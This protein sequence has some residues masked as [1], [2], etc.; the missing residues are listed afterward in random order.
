M[1]HTEQFSLLNSLIIL[2]LLLTALSMFQ[3]RPDTNLTIRTDMSDTL[4]VNDFCSIPDVNLQ[5][6]HSY[7]FS[8]TQEDNR[9]YNGLFLLSA[10]LVSAII[11]LELSFWIHRFRHIFDIG[12]FKKIIDF[13]LASDGKKYELFFSF[14]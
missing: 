6:S 8:H 9:F 4:S 14:I 11:L 13:I 1:R 10:L 5:E 2:I 7:E 3:T 12:N